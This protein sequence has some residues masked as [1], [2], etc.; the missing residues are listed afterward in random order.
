MDGK[1]SDAL[2]VTPA[3]LERPLPFDKVTLSF[4]WLVGGAWVSAQ[5]CPAQSSLRH[6]CG[7][8]QQ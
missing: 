5:S 8:T 6:S 7:P 4:P 1:Q 3:D 2:W